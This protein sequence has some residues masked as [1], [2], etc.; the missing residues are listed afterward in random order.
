MHKIFILSDRH[1]WNRYLR[2]YTCNQQKKLKKECNPGILD[3]T[4]CILIIEKSGLLTSGL[5]FTGFWR[6]GSDLMDEFQTSVLEVSK[7]N[8]IP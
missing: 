4:V 3:S 8:Y 6:V 5:M 1:H 2:N 7:T